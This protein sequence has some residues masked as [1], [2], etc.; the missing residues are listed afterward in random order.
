MRG[1][2]FPSEEHT[3]QISSLNGES[4]KHI[5]VSN[6]RGTKGVIFLYLRMYIYIHTYTFLT[7]IVFF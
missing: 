7:A 1:I 2:A 4:L 6:I 3:Y 5:Y